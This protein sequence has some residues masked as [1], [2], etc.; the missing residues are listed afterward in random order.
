MAITWSQPEHFVP[1]RLLTK[2]KANQNP[3][4]SVEKEMFNSLDKI[5]LAVK[6][7]VSGKTFFYQRNFAIR[8]GNAGGM[9]SLVDHIEKKPF[10]DGLTTSSTAGHC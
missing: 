5:I 9:P 3:S 4:R 2:V 10:I 7:T 1:Y 6:P 8:A